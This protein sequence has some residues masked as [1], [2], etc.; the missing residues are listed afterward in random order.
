MINELILERMLLESPLEFCGIGCM[1]QEERLFGGVGCKHTDCVDC[2]YFGKSGYGCPLSW[3]VKLGL[4]Y[5]SMVL[6]KKG[7][8]ISEEIY[9]TEEMIK[10]LRGY[11]K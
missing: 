3:L 5:E 7:V 6:S 10:T 11:L 4:L 8:L 2:C 9:V 1:F